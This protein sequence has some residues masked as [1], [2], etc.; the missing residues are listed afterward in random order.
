[1]RVQDFDQSAKLDP[2]VDS[3]VKRQLADC[4]A[5]PHAVHLEQFAHLRGILVDRP[6]TSP[7][8]RGLRATP[9]PAR[10]AVKRGL[11]FKIRFHLAPMINRIS[12]P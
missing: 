7:A 4:P 5:D 11:C 2:G 8:V 6:L 9:L 10:S 1:M 12:F 3:L